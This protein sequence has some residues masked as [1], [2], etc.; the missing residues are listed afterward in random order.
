[1]VR[2]MMLL[3]SYVVV[4]RMWRQRSRTQWVA[5]GDKNTKY[6]HGVATQRKRRNFIKVVRDVDEVWEFD[7]GVVLNIFVDYYNRLF[8]QSNIHDLDQELEGV[9]RVVTVD[10]NFKLVKPYS[11]DEVDATIKQMALLK[12]LRPDGMPPFFTNP[13]VRL[14]VRMFW[15]LS[16]HA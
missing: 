16:F 12:A 11:K 4:S 7:E 9:K 14:L 3:V 8:T 1:M 5:K 6:F 10:I 13:F 15:K 2:I